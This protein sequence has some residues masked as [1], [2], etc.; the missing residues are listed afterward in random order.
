[1]SG[2][3]S[4]TSARVSVDNGVVGG[5]LAQGKRNLHENNNIEDLSDSELDAQN[6]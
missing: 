3:L 6:P 5:V 2:V 1:M 4:T